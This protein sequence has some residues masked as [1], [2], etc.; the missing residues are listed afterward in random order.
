MA[1]SLL[2]FNLGVELGQIAIVGL[3]WPALVWVNRR[4]WAPRFRCVASIGIFLLGA[5]W[6]VE[7]AFGWRMFSW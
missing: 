7:R 5:L 1:R 4:S 3:L 2:S 6:F